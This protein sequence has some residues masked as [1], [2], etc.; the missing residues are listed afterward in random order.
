[1]ISCNYCGTLNSIPIDSEAGQY[2]GRCGGLIWRSRKIGIRWTIA[3]TAAALVLYVPANILPILSVTRLGQYSENT[4]ISGVS[5][6]IHTGMWGIAVVVFLASV[7]VPLLKIICLLYL[8]FAHKLPQQR[9]LA[10]E[11]YKVVHTIG[12]WSMLDV[13]VVAVLVSLVQLGDLASVSAEPGLVAFT[14]VVILTTLASQTFDPRY[15][16]RDSTYKISGNPKDGVSS[17]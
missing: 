4:V 7:A 12:P 10:T 5:E 8:C 3:F 13:F 1:M 2:C 17:E 15:I 16:W 14:A 11:I 6:L 9:K